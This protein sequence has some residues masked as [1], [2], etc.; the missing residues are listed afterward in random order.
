MLSKR[1]MVV[2]AEKPL[3]R[4]L[5]AGAMAAGG[6]VQ[7]F[8]SA[9]ELPARIETDLVLYAL[10]WQL[11]DPG[12]QSL[13]ARLPEGARVVPV[14]HASQLDWMI[15]LLEDKRIASVLVAEE[16]GGQMISSV[17]SK[18]LYADL[19]GLE[20]VMPWGV[21]IYSMLVGD[22]QEKSLAI[23]TIGDFA[24][25]MGV[26]RKYRE[27]IDQCI[28]EML[29]NA[30]YDAPVDETGK[31]LFAD[32]SVKERVALRL[33]EKAVVQYACDGDRFAV[34]VRDSFGSLSKETVLAYLDK[35]LHATGADQIDRKAGGAGLGLYLIANSATEVYFHV[36]EGA[37]TEVMCCF[38]LQAA[39]SQLRVFGVFEESIRSAARP[40]RASERTVSARQGRRR[41]DIAPVPRASALL[42]VMMTFAVLLLITAVTLVAL[43]YVRHAPTAVLRV[44]T[45]PP[46]A[47]VFVDGRTR[48]TAPL[49]VAGLEAGRSYAVRST[50]AGHKEDDQ[51]VTAAAG[52]STIRL[53]LPAEA[54][55][56]AVESDPPGARVVVDGKDTGK[57]A[58]TSLELQAG[59][60]YEVRLMLDGYLEQMLRVTAPPAGEHAVYRA[61]LPLSNQVAALSIEAT[62][63][64]ATVTVDGLA[65][66]PPAKVHETFVKPGARHVVRAQAPGFVEGREEVLLAGGERRKLKLTLVEGGELALKAN[67]PAKV[68]IDDKPI[69][70]AP[71]APMTLAEGPHKLK[72]RASSPPLEYETRVTI[73]KGRTVEEKLEFG[74]VE[75][76]AAGVLAHP[77]GEGAP[78]VTELQLL[79]GP[80]KLLLSKDGETRERELNVPAGKKLIVDAW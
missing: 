74:T 50:L 80:R 17:V 66:L 6:A 42:P 11:Q 63:E 15:K 70:T 77:G 19:F 61:A 55:A 38:D 9:D 30:L 8:T 48:G 43:P 76:K 62:P 26:R 14:L 13:L 54:S 47:T 73:E 32:V 28:D 10:G 75:I 39:R 2:A 18:L 51:L 22:Y 72:L 79:A 4:R 67:V 59:R 41:E 7:G 23:A 60:A 3:Q 1:V 44:E 31:P 33:A 78:G 24:Q 36:F 12:L 64:A 40:T 25:A 56:I 52:E 69:G 5:I 35:C 65:L 53:R 58:P 29:M 71:L 16:L 37:A 21:R 34:S 49:T 68:F 57:R 45:D 46:G 27:Q 20:K